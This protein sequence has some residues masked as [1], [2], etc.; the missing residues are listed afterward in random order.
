MRI[1]GICC[2]ECHRSYLVGGDSVAQ[3]FAIL[4]A[5]GWFVGEQITSFLCPDCRYSSLS[6]ES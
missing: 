2:D 1:N 5:E 6:K 3:M 4:K